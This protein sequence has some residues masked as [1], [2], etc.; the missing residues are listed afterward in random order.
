MEF[1]IENKNFI[2]I[3]KFVHKLELM[4][5]DVLVK[6]MIQVEYENIKMPKDWICV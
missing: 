2:A 3:R 4:D 6:A 5:L 1:C